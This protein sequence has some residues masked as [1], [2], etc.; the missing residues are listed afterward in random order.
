MKVP[1]KKEAKLFIGLQTAVMMIKLDK[2]TT[3]GITTPAF[4]IRF[5]PFLLF[6]I[7]KHLLNF[8]I[9]AFISYAFIFI[10]LSTASFLCFLSFSLPFRNMFPLFFHLY[11]SIPITLLSLQSSICINRYH[12]SLSNLSSF[13]ISHLH[14][15]LFYD[16]NTA[17]LYSS[18]SHFFIPLYHPSL[19]PNF[20]LLNS[21]LWYFSIPLYHPSLFP[22]ITLLYSPLPFFSIPVYHTVLLYFHLHPYLISAI[23][24]LYFHPRP[25]LFSAKM[26]LYFPP[27][28]F[29]ILRY[30]TIL[31]CLL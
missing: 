7:N 23:I 18:L 20:T 17:L 21:P 25:Y 29:S 28:S 15:S 31:I 5:F 4:F 14:T 19:L 12:T 3:F 16:I 8:S 26:L 9:T 6:S 10:R 24:P 30:N 13:S 22:S 11:S 27:S 1:K 2:L